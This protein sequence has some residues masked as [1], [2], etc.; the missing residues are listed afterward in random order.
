MVSEE[1]EQIMDV[2]R[3]Q[4]LAEDRYA[5]TQAPLR[6]SGRLKAKCMNIHR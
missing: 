6:K 3:R 5:E 1:V 2:V 4:A